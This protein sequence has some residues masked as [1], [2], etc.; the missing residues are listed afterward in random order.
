LG[1]SK[2]QLARLTCPH[3]EWKNVN[4]YYVLQLDIDATEEDIKY[5]SWCVEFVGMGVGVT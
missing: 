5:R 1:D 4:P 2:A 3:Y